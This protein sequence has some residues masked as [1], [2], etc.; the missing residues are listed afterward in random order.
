ML[1]QLIENLCTDLEIVP[2]PKEEKQL[3]FEL[4]PNL[5]VSLEDL[6]PGVAFSAPLSPCPPARREELFTFLMRAN[7]LGQGTGGAAIGLSPDETQLTLSAAFPYEISPPSFREKLE[8]FINYLLYW[9]EEIEKFEQE[10]RL[11]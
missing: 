4:K 5:R 6:Q 2:P 3:F 7:L 11:L 1:R 10:E 9:R 8:Q